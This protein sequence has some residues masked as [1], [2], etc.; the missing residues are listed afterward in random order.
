M[1]GFLGISGETPTNTGNKNYS[2][3]GF[4]WEI[5]EDLRSLVKISIWI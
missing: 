1:G 4:L 3:W 5:Y 2:C